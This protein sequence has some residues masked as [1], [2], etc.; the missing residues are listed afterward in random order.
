MADT[1]PL[2]TPSSQH[3]PPPCTTSRHAPTPD[4]GHKED[5]VAA[6]HNSRPFPL[7]SPVFP[8]RDSCSKLIIGDSS[9]KSVARQRVD[10]T[11][12]TNVRTFIRATVARLTNIISTGACYPRVEQ[13]MVAIGT[14]DCAGNM[15]CD[16]AADYQKLLSAIK[17]HFPTADVAAAAILAQA[18]S[19]DVMTRST[20]NKGL[21][22]LCVS[23]K[24][25]FMR[26]ST[27][28]QCCRQGR[29]DPGILTDKVHLSVKSLSLLLHD[30]QAFVSPSCTR[31]DRPSCASAVKSGQQLQRREQQPGEQKRHQ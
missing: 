11:G 7:F 15:P 16:I 31:S 24:V 5:P 21:G 18:I 3:P 26:L 22:N 8:L 20:L 23:N 4:T 14:N 12:Y 6:S 17:A 19:G 30:V 1:P 27:L 10:S 29:V 25:H 9:L 13:V 2:T 28:W